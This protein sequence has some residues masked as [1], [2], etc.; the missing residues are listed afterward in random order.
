MYYWGKRTYHSEET[1]A[2]T[3]FI[4]S[5]KSITG[6]MTYLVRNGGKRGGVGVL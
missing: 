4:A 1:D 5:T 3:D 2:A 6:I